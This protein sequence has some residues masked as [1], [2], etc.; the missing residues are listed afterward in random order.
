VHVPFVTGINKILK[1]EKRLI[2]HLHR[3]I[4]VFKVDD[5]VDG[6][7]RH[8]LEVPSFTSHLGIQRTKD[9][10]LAHFLK[11]E[12]LLSISRKLLHS[13]SKMFDKKNYKK[14]ENTIGVKMPSFVMGDQLSDR[15]ET[16]EKKMA[17]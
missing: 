11:I 1:I 12:K 2:I 7:V 13:L 3:D 6:K 5:T 15:I 10:S 9:G 4:I 14:V 16:E 8:C 17:V